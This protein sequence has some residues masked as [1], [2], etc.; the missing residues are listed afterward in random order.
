MPIMR[1]RPAQ[2]QKM[3]R[4]DDVGRFCGS[5]A[6]H[7]LYWGA[8]AG[9][10]KTEQP[11]WI[12]DPATYDQSGGRVMRTIDDRPWVRM[13][14]KRN[15]AAFAQLEW[16][17]NTRWLLRGGLRHDRVQADIPTFSTLAGSTID[18][19]SRE[20]SDTLANIGVVYILGTDSRLFVSFAQGFSLPDIGLVLRSAPAGAS[21]DTLPFQ[22]QIVHGWEAGWQQTRGALSGNLSAFYSTS[23]FGTS[24][25]G[26]N[27]PVV[28]APER[29][30]GTEGQVEYRPAGA[31]AVGAIASW[32]EGKHD[33]NRD[34]IYTYLNNY[35]IPGPNGTAWF[36]HQTTRSWRN[37]VQVLWS[38]ER[39]RF[40]ASTAFGERPIESY[41]VVDLLS[42]FDLRR[43]QLYVGV[44]NAL[45]AEY[46]VRDAQ[47]LRSGRNDSYTAA[48]GATLSIGWSMRY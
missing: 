41:T 29:V 30:Y 23:E 24:T 47:L 27:Q 3:W 11:V 7:R 26:F 13:I 36:E 43:G 22:P 14:D 39:D 34:G 8:D 28:R 48:P 44:Q 37:R 25:A 19:G 20:F 1:R 40:G 46:F 15:Q 38:G 42:T 9:S 18:G 12:M 6:R 17:A 16:V 4:G 5:L 31:W 21:L 33:P 35:R 2:N 32:T 10:E 45:N